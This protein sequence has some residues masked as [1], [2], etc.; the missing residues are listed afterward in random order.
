MQTVRILFTALLLACTT[1]TAS[2]KHTK[3]IETTPREVLMDYFKSIYGK[4][5]LSGAMANVNWNTNEA[6]WVYRLT[7][8]YPVINSFDFIH[9]FS[10]KPG[11]WIDYSNATTAEQWYE[12]G[13]IVAALWHWNV[14]ARAAGQYAF[15]T[16][17]TDF[18]VR[19]VFD[20]E[21]AEYALMIHDIDQIAAFLKP[22]CEKR[23]P[24]IW[25]P[26]HEAGGRWFWWGVDPEACK[27]LWRI[28]HERFDQA[29]LNNLVWTWT[30]ATE[31]NK[32]FEDGLRWYPGD[33]YVDIVGIDIYNVKDPLV[34]KDYFMKMEQHYPGK[35][36]A[37]TECGNVPSIGSQWEAG[38]RWLFFMPWYDYGRTCDMKS[39]ASWESTHQHCNIAWWREAWQHNY[40]IQK[41]G[42][43]T[44]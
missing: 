2:A 29:G 41:H 40:V 38:A 25:R 36:V 24:I 11:G 6:K 1:T 14:P 44:R 19:K 12:S 31:W 21:S 43:K 42:V 15:Y 20:R 5:T 33:E 9:H 8:A 37:L 3:A 7:G 23:I 32:P 34:C 17:D 30:H 26:L 10:S 18:D 22:L 28:M 4:Q 27:E 35:M 39:P 13:G 16:K